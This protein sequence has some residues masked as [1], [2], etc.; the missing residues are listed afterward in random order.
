ME[1]EDITGSPLKVHADPVKTVD[2]EAT[3]VQI[4]EG[5]F[6]DFVKAGL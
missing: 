2:K 4:P 3:A 6:A 1:V 5:V